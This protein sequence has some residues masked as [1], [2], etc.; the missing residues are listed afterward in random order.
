M[1]HQRYLEEDV[2][3]EDQES[4]STYKPFACL[5]SLLKDKK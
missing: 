4:S 1:E 2:L 5:E 3:H